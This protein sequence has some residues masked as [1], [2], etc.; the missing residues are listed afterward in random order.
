MRKDSCEGTKKYFEGKLDDADRQAGRYGTARSWR[1]LNSTQ[2]MGRDLTK[3]E[4]RELMDRRKEERKT[5]T[6]RKKINEKIQ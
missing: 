4:V 3:E 2:V 1:K 6:E 5:K